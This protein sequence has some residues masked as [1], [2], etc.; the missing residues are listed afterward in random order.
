MTLHQEIVYHPPSS[1][2]GWHQ[3]HAL[4]NFLNPVD[5]LLLYE[6]D[7]RLCPS[8]FG[9]ELASDASEGRVEL[10]CR[11][12]SRVVGRWSRGRCWSSSREKR[13]RE[14]VGEGWL[15]YGEEEVG[16]LRSGGRVGVR[17]EGERI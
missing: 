9:A 6:F 13:R 17:V 15:G 12:G 2:S 1:R 11:L 7:E 4:S 10:A 8:A 5:D 3:N 16:N 14:G